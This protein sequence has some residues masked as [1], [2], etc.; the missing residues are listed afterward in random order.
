MLIIFHNSEIV[1]SR[2][3]KSRLT[4]SNFGDSTFILNEMKSILSDSKASIDVK[5][6][7]FVYF[8]TFS[9][10]IELVGNNITDK[11]RT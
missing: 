5:H 9:N 7:Y 8:D 3:I 2:F 11:A 10:W 1:F 4:N 6:G